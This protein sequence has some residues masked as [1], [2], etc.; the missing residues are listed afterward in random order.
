MAETYQTNGNQ[1][2]EK[3]LNE[4]KESKWQELWVNDRNVEV[5]TKTKT[6]M[7]WSKTKKV[8]T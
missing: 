6:N 4:D 7:T 1:L 2:I 5:A 3:D 8:C